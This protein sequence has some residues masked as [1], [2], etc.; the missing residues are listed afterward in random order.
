LSERLDAVFDEPSI[1]D[2]WLEAERGIGRPAL[3]GRLLLL[4]LGTGGQRSKGEAIGCLVT[5]GVV[6]RVPRRFAVSGMTRERIATGAAAMQPVQPKPMAVIAEG[7]A[8]RVS[9]Y[10]GVPTNGQPHLRLVHSRD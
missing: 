10:A 2:I 7:F 4:P 8:D 1:L 5:A 3:L 9:T 6:G